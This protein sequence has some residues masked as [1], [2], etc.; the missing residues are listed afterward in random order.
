M[1]EIMSQKTDQEENEKDE[2]M[3]NYGYFHRLA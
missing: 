3:T 2:R 1:S